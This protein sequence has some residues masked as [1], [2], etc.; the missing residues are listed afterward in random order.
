MT[1]KHDVEKDNRTSEEVVRN[2]RYFDSVKRAKHL[3][4]AEVAN[5]RR[6]MYEIL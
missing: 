1:F 2:P 4:L 3:S 6:D 5:K